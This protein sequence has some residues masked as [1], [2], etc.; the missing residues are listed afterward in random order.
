MYDLLYLPKILLKCS[1]LKYCLKK[2]PEVKRY[3][4]ANPLSNFLK[5]FKTIQIS[6]LHRLYFITIYNCWSCHWCYIYMGRG[7]PQCTYFHIDG[8]LYF[9]SFSFILL[10]V[11]TSQ[12][13]FSCMLNEN[14]S[15]KPPSF[16]IIW[17]LTN[18]N[19]VQVWIMQKYFSIQDELHDNTVVALCLCN[20]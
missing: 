15:I 10:P 19:R 6:S 7:C 5:E 13:I 20:K 2:I 4:P 1:C 17:L 9:S 8:H 16:S 11:L 18:P 12:I 3:K 14:V